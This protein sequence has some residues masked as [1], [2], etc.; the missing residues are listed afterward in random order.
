MLRLFRAVS[1]REH[2]AHFGRALLIVAGVATG[3]ALMVAFDVMNASVITGFRQTFTALAGPA[4][5]EVT[6]GVGEVGFPEDVADVGAA[7]R[8]VR[9]TVVLESMT[10]GALATVLGLVL[11][12]VT[13]WMWVRILIPRLIGYDLTFAFAGVRSAGSLAVVLLM[14]VAAGWA[15]A[16]RATRRPVLEDIRDQ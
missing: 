3:I 5:L 7:E 11:G 16:T 1:L 2:R 9:H 15:A 8:S 14:T 12:V 4:D 10:L 6:L 13:S